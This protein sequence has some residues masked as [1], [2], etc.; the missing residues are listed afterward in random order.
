[1]EWQEHFI[2]E[3]WEIWNIGDKTTDQM[4]SGLLL[5]VQAL[6]DKRAE[7]ITKIEPLDSDIAKYIEDIWEIM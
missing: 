5:V 3:Y 1:M 4:L 7:I 6:L 2:K